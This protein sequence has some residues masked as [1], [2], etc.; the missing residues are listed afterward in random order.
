METQGLLLSRQLFPPITVVKHSVVDW[1]TKKPLLLDLIN[2]EASLGWHECHTDYFTS[3]G[4]GPYFD[5]WY[6][7]MKEDLDSVLPGFGLPFSSLDRW[8]LW[9][10]KYEKGERHGLHN[11]GFGSMSAILYV[12]FDPVEH[13][14]TTFYPPFPDPF[15]GDIKSAV[16]PDIQEGDIIF[17]P[18]MLGH[19]APP[20][21]SDKIRTIMSFNI[22]VS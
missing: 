19:E 10:Q 7:I 3:Y 13:T 16:L 15:F 9:S 18:A 8:Q 11:H 21:Y 12:E 5:K 22:P 20:H 2:N 6:D 1:E 17:F 4:R 14:S